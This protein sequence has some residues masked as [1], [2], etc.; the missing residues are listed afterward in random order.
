MV[1]AFPVLAYFALGAWNR[2]D[3]CDGWANHHASRAKQLRAE[4]QDPG[5]APDQRR[6][7]L[8]AADC[9]DHISHKYAQTAAQPWRPYPRYP[10]LTPD[11]QRIAASN[12]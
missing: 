4:A 2:H 1:A 6:E 7:L 12:H 9:H 3:F 8:I 11:E 5:L 10:L